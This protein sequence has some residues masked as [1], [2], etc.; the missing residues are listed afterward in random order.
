MPDADTK[1][2]SLFPVLISLGAR[3]G[4]DSNSR[5]TGNT[6]GSAF[7]SQEITLSY[8]RL[9]GATQIGLLAGAGVVERFT[10]KTDVNAFLNLSVSHRVS[11][12][13]SLSANVDTAYRVEPDFSTDVGPNQRAGNYF[14]TADSLAA[15]YQW[16]RRFSTVTSASFRLIR[17]E[18]NFVAAFTDRNEYTLGEEF[19]FDFSR[20]TVLVANYRFLIVDYLS[21]PRDSL[22]HVALFGVEETF[23]PRLTAQARAGASFRSFDQGEN[24]MDPHFEGSLTYAVA[25]RSMLSWTTRYSV[26]EPAVREA[27]SRT[28]FRTGLQ[29][30]Y[31]F[32]AKLS[33]ALSLFYHHDNNTTTS[34]GVTSGPATTT[35]A[36]DVGLFT[37]YQIS[38]HVDLSASI[39]HSEVSSS[40]ASSDYSRN[41][42][43]L[44][45]NF[46]F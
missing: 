19:R 23:G 30:T 16:N 29:L 4:Y 26:E 22:T 24:R 31:G 25:R 35:D 36:I 3:L 12:R 8:D 9:R 40:S 39:Q 43:S 38:R 6:Q 41:S 37:R 45:M 10:Q 33:S 1:V 15:S 34:A 42:F 46:T 13:L 21:F 14:R 32:T 28:T 18:D 11:Q 2:D 27:Q 17:Y 7:S 20:Q 44:G 5:T